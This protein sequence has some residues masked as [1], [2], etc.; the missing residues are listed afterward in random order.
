M[1]NNTSKG[2]RLDICNNDSPNAFGSF[3]GNIFVTGGQTTACVLN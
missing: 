1:N 3:T 2:N